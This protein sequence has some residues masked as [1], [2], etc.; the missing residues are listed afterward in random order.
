[1]H[2]T[3]M[4]TVRCSGRLLGGCLPGGVY[5]SPRGQTD[6]CENIESI[7]FPQLLLRTVNN[8]GC[9]TSSSDNSISSSLSSSAADFFPFLFALFFRINSLDISLEEEKMADDQGPF[10]PGVKADA[11]DQWGLQSDFERIV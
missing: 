8:C 7:T 9:C 1:M 2:S 11:P 5:T 6:T 3:R 4:R 10:T